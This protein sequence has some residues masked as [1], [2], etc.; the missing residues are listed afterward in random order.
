VAEV[1]EVDDDKPKQQP[2]EQPDASAG[3]PRFGRLLLVLALTIALI[4]LIV[5]ASMAWVG[6]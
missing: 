5:T 3:I 1:G 4:V 2:P 6:A